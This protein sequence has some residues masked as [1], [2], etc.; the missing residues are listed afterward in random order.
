MK[1]ITEADLLVSKQIKKVLLERKQ[2]HVF[3]AN[4]CTFTRQ[5]LFKYVNGKDRVSFGAV[6][7]IADA[8]G[9]EFLDLMPP[10]FFTLNSLFGKVLEL[11]KNE[12]HSVNNIR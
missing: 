1:R 9:C 12:V 7:Q 5:Q 8:V 4:Q 3:I 11:Q 10:E 6:K 2:T